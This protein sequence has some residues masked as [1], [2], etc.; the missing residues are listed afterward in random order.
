M[1]NYEEIIAEA[2]RIEYE[3]KT[4]RLFIVFEVK[5]EKY[6][7]DI[8]KNWISDIEYKIIDK[9]LVNADES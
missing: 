7:R 8:K 3:E 6:K 1:K 9:N 5:S 4:G 2:S